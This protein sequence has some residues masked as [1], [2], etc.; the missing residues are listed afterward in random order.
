MNYN[1]K[2][3]RSWCTV[4]ETRFEMPLV[5]KYEGLDRGQQ[6]RIKV[7]YAGDR[8]VKV[9]LA[10]GKDI[11]LHPWM[12]KPLPTQPFECD[13]PAGATADG[14]LT[15]TFEQEPG[16]GGSGRGCQVAEVWVMPVH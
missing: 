7:T 16:G 5:M 10:A 12:N 13:L 2:W 4:A 14:T 1:P 9:R 15:L 3:R 11:E 6:Y 8:D